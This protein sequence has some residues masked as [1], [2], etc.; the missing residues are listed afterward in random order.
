VSKLEISRNP[1]PYPAPPF[2]RN[3]FRLP[4]GSPRPPAAGAL[5]WR[6]SGP[7]TPSLRSDGVDPVPTPPLP[8]RRHRDLGPMLSVQSA[9]YP[10]L[11]PRTRETSAAPNEPHL[12]VYV[13]QGGAA[14]APGAG[15]SPGS[16]ARH[17][18]SPTTQEGAS[19]HKRE[20]PPP[21]QKRET[22]HE[23]CLTSE[24]FGLHC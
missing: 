19:A 21:T 11:S 22:H 5:P 17:T 10:V 18:E 12:Q 6:V 1:G 15:A 16:G 20:A 24:K 2:G 3:G 13:G 8:S 7:L 4:T 14:A 23:T 9:D